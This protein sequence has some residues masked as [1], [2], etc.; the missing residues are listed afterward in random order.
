MGNKQVAILCNHKRT[1]NQE[2]FEKSEVK[3]RE[4]IEKCEGDLKTLQR[5][6][7]IAQGKGKPRNSDDQK[8]LKKDPNQV[9]KQLDK[10]KNQLQKLKMDKQLKLE[11]KEVALG[12]SKINY[13][14]PRITVAFAKK[15][16]LPIEKVFNK[17]LLDKFPWAMAASPD[18]VF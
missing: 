10:K 13:N 7:K 15:L 8:W 18:F 17:A 1:V 12:T 16:E 11:N 2:V 5:R 6:Y 14:D 3:M 9:K 4:K